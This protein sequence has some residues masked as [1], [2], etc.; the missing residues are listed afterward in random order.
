MRI[1]FWQR[2]QAHP[3]KAIDR[4]QNC[5][6]ARQFIGLWTPADFSAVTAALVQVKGTGK[7]ARFQELGAETTPLEDSAQQA[8]LEL[9]NDENPTEVDIQFASSELS[10]SKPVAVALCWHKRESPPKMW[11]P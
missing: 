3:T 1:P 7:F 11:W 4:L 10:S 8:L 5:R 6:S 2:D 9:Q